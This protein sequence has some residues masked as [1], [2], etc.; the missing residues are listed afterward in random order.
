MRAVK[1]LSIALAVCVGLVLIPWAYFVSGSISDN[2]ADWAQFGD[3]FGG[4]FASLVAALALLALLYTISQQHE[5]IR[6]LKNQASK[7]DILHAIDRLERDFEK[8]LD[9]FQVTVQHTGVSYSVTARDV[10]FKLTFTEH[11]AAIPTKEEIMKQA[12]S[13]PGLM[14]GD[15]RVLL[16]EAFGLAAGELN[17]IRLYAEA[18]HK[19]EQVSGS[20]LL[21]R[22][23]E[24]KYAV[25]YGRLRSRGLLEKEWCEKT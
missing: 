13:S 25:A 21:A 11:E 5:Q 4:T 12:D 18:L 16:Y 7:E 24:R 6:S 17:Q 3:Y 10:L 2:P 15:P 22:Y 1:L 8:A 9:G 20:N 23:Y 14:K 19:L